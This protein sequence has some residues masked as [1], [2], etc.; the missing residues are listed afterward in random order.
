MSGDEDHNEDYADA[1]LAEL[2]LDMFDDIPMEVDD[3]DEEEEEEGIDEP[4]ESIQKPPPVYLPI[5]GANNRI[6]L[7]TAAEQRAV[8][9]DARKLIRNRLPERSFESLVRFIKPQFEPTTDFCNS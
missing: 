9:K 1:E 2:D 6:F 7:A 3:E 8:S 4:D 5:N